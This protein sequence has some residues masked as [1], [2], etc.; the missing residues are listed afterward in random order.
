MRTTISTLFIAASALT[1]AACSSPDE[2]TS[3]EGDE[4]TTEVDA[5]E[6]E[7]ETIVAVAQGNE[8][9][10]TLVTAVVAAD[11]AETLSG[12]GPFTVFAPNNAAF[13]KV[14]AETM[15]ELTKPESKEALAGIL[16]YHVVAGQVLAADLLKLIADNGG[17]ATL[18]TV[19]GGTMTAKLDGENVILT[20]ANGGTATVIATDVKASNGVIH[21]IDT[22]VMPSA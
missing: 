21:A 13:D 17:E 16:T 12:D 6:V 22:V 20:D 11:L 5:T 14:G 18:T 15:A 2:T 8:D 10:S 1:L 9:F 7:G 19:N 3:V 4:T